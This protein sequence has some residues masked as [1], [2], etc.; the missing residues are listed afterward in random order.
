[1]DIDSAAKVPVK[2]LFSGP[3]AGVTGAIYVCRTSGELNLLTF[4]VGGTSTDVSIVADGEPSFTQNSQMGGFPVNI[5]TIDIF[6]IGAG[7]GSIGWLDK[8][9]LLKL[10]PE[11]AGSFPGPACYGRSERATLTDAFF[12]CGYLSDRNFAAGRVSVDTDLAKKAIKVIA[13]FAA[14][15]YAVF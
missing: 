11:S 13:C 3:A 12:V 4:D 10:G 5:P 14:A 8:G 7:G 2:T 9:G 15:E 6:S 1:M